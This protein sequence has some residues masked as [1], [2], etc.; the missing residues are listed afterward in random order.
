[1]LLLQR[2]KRL[3]R[4][5]EMW[6][7]CFDSMNYY[8]VMASFKNFLFHCDYEKNYFALRDTPFLSAFEQ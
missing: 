4:V 1:M 2:H 5:V 8:G 3:I 7:T 6:T